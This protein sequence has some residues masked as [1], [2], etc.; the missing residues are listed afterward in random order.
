M[1]SVIPSHRHKQRLQTFFVF[2]KVQLLRLSLIVSGMQNRMEVSDQTLCGHQPNFLILDEPTNH[3]DVQTIEALG[4]AI[5]KYKVS[6]SQLSK[7]TS[8]LKQKCTQ[9]PT[10]FWG[11]V[12]HAISLGVIHFV[13]SVRS[14]NHYF[15]G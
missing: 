6:G 8:D 15:I 5:L 1:V 4:N 10:P 9:L 13:R 7:I 11:T 3:L 12:F 14:I 2:V